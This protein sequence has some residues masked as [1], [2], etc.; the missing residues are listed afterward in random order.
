MAGHEAGIL[1]AEKRRGAGHL[2]GLARPHERHG[3]DV[4]VAIV[5]VVG[6]PIRGSGV[7]MSPGATAFTRMPSGPYSAAIWRVSPAMPALADV[8]AACFAMPKIASLRPC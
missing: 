2:R 3:A 4:A 5:G 6:E 7:S 8:Y 1:A